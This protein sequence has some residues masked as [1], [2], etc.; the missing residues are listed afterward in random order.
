MRERHMDLKLTDKVAIVTGGGGQTGYGRNI[1]LT[2]AQEGCHIVVADIDISGAENTA[3]QVEALGRKAFAVKVDVTDRAEVNAMTKAARDRFGRIDILCNNAGASSREK[4]FMEMTRADWDLDIDVNLIGQMNV[5]QSVL[6][7]MIE[8]KYGRII[9]TTGGRGIPGISVYGAAKAGV[10]AWTHA[11]AAEVAQF[12]V[13]VNGVAPG[14]GDTGLT[15]TAPPGFKE[16]NVQRSMLKRL[17]RPEDVGPAV[18]FLASD[19][20]SYMTGQFLDLSTL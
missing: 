2:L 11:L 3:R 20:C 4:P 16:V 14:L 10:V 15:K 8:Q 17:C 13:V 6:P 19:V 9:N 12:G 1:A 7:Y 5:A 18:A